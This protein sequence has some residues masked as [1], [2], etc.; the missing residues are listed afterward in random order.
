MELGLEPER[1]MC[2]LQGKWDW[3][4]IVVLDFG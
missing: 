3:I 2:K 1:K 4:S